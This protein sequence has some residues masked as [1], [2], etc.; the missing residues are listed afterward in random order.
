MSRVSTEEKGGGSAQPKRSIQR[1]PH[2]PTKFQSHPRSATDALGEQPAVR[3]HDQG[4]ISRSS[5]YCENRRP[6]LTL[7]VGWAADPGRESLR[8]VREPTPAPP[9]APS[10]PLLGVLPSEK[11][12]VHL[13]REGATEG[14]EE[15]SGPAALSGAASGPTLTGPTL[16]G[17]APGPTLN[18]AAPGPTLSGAAPGPTLNGAAP[19]PPLNGAAPGPTFSGAAPGP[20]LKGVAPDAPFAGAGGP[21]RVALATNSSD[22]EPPGAE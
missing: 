7:V 22:E 8:D 18:G 15:A 13:G 21:S 14:V 19:G 9:R 6:H 4:D 16:S 2:C 10:F 17:A 12:T 1:R 20:T 11:Q 3:H 5:S